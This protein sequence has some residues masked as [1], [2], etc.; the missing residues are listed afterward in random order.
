MRGLVS[1]HDRTR[2][3]DLGDETDAI[4]FLTRDGG[5]GA[6]LALARDDDD[7]ALAGLVLSEPTIAAVLFEVGRTDVATKVPRN[8]ATTGLGG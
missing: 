8:S 7:A 1:M 5:F 3:H 6:V 4:G 2:L